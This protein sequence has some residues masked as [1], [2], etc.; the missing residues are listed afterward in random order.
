MSRRTL[1]A[2]AVT[3]TVAAIPTSQAATGPAVS[4]TVSS[5]KVKHGDAV[6]L[7]GNVGN[8][9]AG[10]PVTILARPFTGS[11]F[12][13]A[14]TART[15]EDGAWSFRASPTVATTY[16]ARAGGKPSRML[17]IGVQPAISLAVQPNGRIQVRVEPDAFAN[18]FVR[19]Q[20]QQEGGA[21]SNALK[22]RLGPRSAAVVKATRLPTAAQTLRVALSVNQAGAGYLGSVSDTLRYPARWASLSAAPAELTFGESLTLSGRISA[23]QAG[24]PVTI[25]VRPL[26]K[27]EFQPR[28]TV[29]TAAGGRWSYT[30]E[31]WVSAAYRARLGAAQSRVLSVGV[32]P[33][34]GVDVGSG[35]TVTATVTA[36]RS[37]AG[38]AVQLQQ[39]LVDGTWRTIAR[40]RLD[41]QSRAVFPASA[42]PGGRSVLRVAMSVN[43]AGLGYLAGFSRE[44]A[45]L[46]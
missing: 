24:V 27:A 3:A 42:T 43:Q 41:R 26:A 21:W 20:R 44:F 33:A 36:G 31:P 45:Y 25:L 13:R 17:M 5:F 4:L 8:G 1:L 46:R 15:G 14:G 37:L 9:R 40:Q 32:R 39:R 18:R 23:R 29:T 34:V 16:Q 30:V 19:L 22:L 6:V 11:A 12:Q 38:R 7:S 10:V 2:V 28:A 35:G